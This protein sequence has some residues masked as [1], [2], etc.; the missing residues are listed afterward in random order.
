MLSNW[1]W[2]GKQVIIVNIPIWLMRLRVYTSIY[3]HEEFYRLVMNSIF[4]ECFMLIKVLL[5][6]GFQNLTHYLSMHLTCR[7]A[8]WSPSYKWL[9]CWLYIVYLEPPVRS[10]HFVGI[11]RQDAVRTSGI[12]HERQLRASALRLWSCRPSNVLPWYSSLTSCEKA[13]LHLLMEQNW[14]RTPPEGRTGPSC[15]HTTTNVHPQ[16]FQST[17]FCEPGRTTSIR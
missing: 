10:C 15:A 14:P 6:S 12:P 2:L 4:D 11:Q 8:Q 1:I 3:S 16:G 17:H 9:L 7:R 5:S 13:R